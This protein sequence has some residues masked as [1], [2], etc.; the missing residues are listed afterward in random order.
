M[1][2]LSFFIF[3]SIVLVVYSSLNY[4][5]YSRGLMVFSCSPAYKKWY[6]LVFWTLV[7]SFLVG[8]FWERAASSVVSEWIY[9]VGAFWL[10]FMFY[11]L[12]ALLVID[13]VR[14]TNYFFHF[15][16]DFSPAG[17]LYLG[18]TVIGIVS[19]VVLG[20][21]INALTTRIKEIPLTIH[22]AVTGN[23]ELKIL[24][25]SDLHLGALIGERQEMKL[26]RIINEQK[27]DLVL[28]CGDLVDGDIGPALRKNLGKHIQEI[29]TP[30]GVY[31][32]PGNHE[33]I[34]GIRNTLPY[35]QSINIKVLRDEVVT[36]PNGIQLVGRDD[37]DSRRMGETSQPHE[38]KGLTKGLDH[39]KPII[40]MNHQPFH[41]DEAVEVG[42]DLH[43][44]GHTHHGQMWP[45]NYVTAA[46]FELSWGL[47]QKG[48][49]TFYVSS[50]F[51][52]WGPPV[53][54]G[55]S[56]EVVVFKVRF[57]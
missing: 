26:V 16:P 28:L 18:Y 6:T 50:G 44:S 11:F 41:L 23:P 7:S 24:M 48:N 22:K 55:N 36:L 10:A 45:F 42:A 52:S 38:L 20:G 13:V 9:R 54:I 40:V 37:R 29:R 12:V 34:G 49:T 30:L 27:P 47:K 43:L 33:Y 2:T 8:M 1:R 32:I 21:Y 25:A 17:K 15:L 31:A 35:L 39:T 53:R 56:P 46:I 51:G 4:F 3:F 14:L 57:D 5:V 19:L